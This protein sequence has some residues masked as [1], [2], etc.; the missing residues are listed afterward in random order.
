MHVI[1]YTGQIVPVKEVSKMAHAHGIPVI[2][3]GAHSFNQFPFTVQD[4]ECDFFGTSLHKWTYAPIG[5]GMLY[6][7]KEKIKE[8]WPLMAAP[9]HMDDNIRKFEEIGTHPAANHNAIAE[10]LAF[11]EGIGIDRKAARLQ[12]LHL[13]WINRL[14]KYKNVTFMTN[15]DD[16]SQWCG[17]VNV[18]IKGVDVTK[19]VKYLLDK[20]KIYVIPIL[21][22]EFKGVRVTPNVY[23][24]LSEIDLFADIMEKVARGEVIE[25]MEG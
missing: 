7:K 20:H 10:A 13:R 9:E 23:T 24:L 18:Y 14:R 6:V 3:D 12:Y 4:L 2:C 17:L 5:T 11:N 19:L 8:I 25:V 15:I 22:E 16:L 1:N 21:H